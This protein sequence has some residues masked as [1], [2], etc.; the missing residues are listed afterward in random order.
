MELI[1]LVNSVIIFLSQMTSPKWLTFLHGFQTVILIGLL[2]WIYLFFLTLVFFSTMAFPL[3]GNSDHV[4]VSVSIDVPSSSQRDAPF[5]R[6]A[7]D[8]SHADWDGLRDHLRDV[9]WEDIFKLD[10]SAPT[11]SSPR[12]ENTGLMSSGG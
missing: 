6:I 11:S 4:A 10:V 8:Y 1:D 12:P 5:H 9:L 7:Y 2:S 3:L